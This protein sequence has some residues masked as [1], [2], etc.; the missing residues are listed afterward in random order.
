MK[1]TIAYASLGGATVTWTK[2]VGGVKYGSYTCDG[3][4]ESQ[5]DVQHRQAET[6]ALSCRALP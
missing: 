5:D 6:H 1:D 3:C 4:G 2:H